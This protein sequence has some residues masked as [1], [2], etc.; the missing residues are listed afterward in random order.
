MQVCTVCKN[1]DKNFYSAHKAS[2]HRKTTGHVVQTFKAYQKSLQKAKKQEEAT[3]T[4][5]DEEGEP[6]TDCLGAVSGKSWK[7]TA[8]YAP[9]DFTQPIQ[10]CSS[11]Y[12]KNASW[13]KHKVR[14]IQK[15]KPTNKKPRVEKQITG[16]E[17]DQAWEKQQ[18]IRQNCKYSD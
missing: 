5:K 12:S 7:S 8:I 17:V 15:S 16:G 11:N 13:C 3:E 10:N 4:E 6:K 1:E 18:E 14:V 2:D 9:D